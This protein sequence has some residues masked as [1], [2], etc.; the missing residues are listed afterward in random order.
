ADENVD[1]TPPRA[2][3]DDEAQVSHSILNGLPHLKTQRRLDGLTL[4][5]IANFCDVSALRLG[6]MPWG[7]EGRL[8]S[9]EDSVV[10]DLK[11]ENKKLVRD[12][13]GLR[14]LS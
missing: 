1:A 13:A 6:A 4:N 7:T 12:I 3:R 5:E 9:K 14:K 2:L 8:A 10:R 11:A